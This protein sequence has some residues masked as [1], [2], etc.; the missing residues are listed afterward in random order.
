MPSQSEIDAV[1]YDLDTD[2]TTMPDA[3]I[4]ILY[5]RA[6]ARYGVGT[7]STEFYVRII[8]IRRLLAGAVK[9][10]DYVQNQSQEKLSQ[11]R[12]GLL[13]LLKFYKSELELAINGERAAVRF[14]GLRRYNVR[15][16]EFPDD[17]QFPT[18]G[19]TD[20]SRL[21]NP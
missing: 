10:V 20:I 16:V 7:L 9:R 17:W 4:L 11:M 6:E 14:G 18:E 15:T 21:E 5:T 19:G 3:E 12:D 1:R 2:A 8:A 13:A